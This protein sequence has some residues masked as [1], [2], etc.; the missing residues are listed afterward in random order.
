MARLVPGARSG[1]CRCCGPGRCFVCLAGCSDPNS[2]S[3]NL[4]S[5]FD[6][7]RGRQ[8]QIS[9]QHAPLHFSASLYF[10]FLGHKSVSSS[11]CSFGRWAHNCSDPCKL[12]WAL[13]LTLAISA[14]KSSSFLSPRAFYAGIKLRFFCP[15]RLGLDPGS[16]LCPT[17]SARFPRRSR[18]D[19]YLPYH[20]SYGDSKTSLLSPAHHFFRWRPNSYQTFRK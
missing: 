13:R 16:L 8:P 15:F 2:S 3:R 17:S 10:L 1:R 14:L 5:S 20:A 7:H 4:R 19:F 12:F 18:K 11:H 9:F 6:L